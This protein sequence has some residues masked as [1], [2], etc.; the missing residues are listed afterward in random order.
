MSC[1]RS[2]LKKNDIQ[3][4]EKTKTMNGRNGLAVNFCDNVSLTASISVKHI[5]YLASYLIPT[6]I[7]FNLVKNVFA[8]QQLAVLAI[9]IVFYDI[10]AQAC[11][12]GDLHL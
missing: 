5:F 11:A 10:L 1:L 4:K 8:T 3:F 6:T 7:S 2:K 12:E 9:R